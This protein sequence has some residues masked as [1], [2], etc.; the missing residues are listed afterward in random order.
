MKCPLSAHDPADSRA[1]WPPV[2]AQVGRWN[3]SGLQLTAAMS[4]CE[5][6]TRHETETKTM[7][8]HAAFH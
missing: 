5:N 6:H 4:S 7:T 1:V 8:R 2:Y 3:H